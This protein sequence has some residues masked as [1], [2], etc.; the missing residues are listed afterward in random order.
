MSAR[1]P[2][3]ALYCRLDSTPNPNGARAMLD[4]PKTPITPFQILVLL[5]ILQ[6]FASMGLAWFWMLWRRFHGRPLLPTVTPRRVP[7]GLES[8]AAILICYVVIA[9]GLSG[10][11]AF[12]SHGDGKPTDQDALVLVAVL[13]FLVLLIVP[14]LLGRISGATWDDLG[15]KWAGMGRNLARGVVACLL[16]APLC[17]GLMALAVQ[18]WPPEEHPVLALVKHGLTPGVAAMT[19]LSAVILAPAAEE[20]LFRGII[21][22]WLEKVFR[23]APAAPSESF[24]ELDEPAD[25]PLVVPQ[26]VTSR[27]AHPTLL[28]LPNVITSIIFAELHAPQWPAPLPLFILSMGLGVLYKRTGS[29]WAPIA[30]HASFNG[31]STIALM[32]AVWSGLPVP[33]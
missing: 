15:L 23:V 6:V 31:L 20:L 29:L 5:L 4:G 9:L 16:L 26:P 33:K 14:P 1:W 7:W 10:H 18:I 2:V 25:G 3:L 28:L 30:L 22:P 17:Y 24:L 12:R 8:I 13:N 32:L 11:R 27:P 19:I 21:M